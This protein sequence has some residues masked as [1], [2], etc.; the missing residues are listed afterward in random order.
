MLQNKARAAVNEKV[1]SD[2]YNDE[3]NVNKS[4]SDE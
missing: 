3:G 1:R 4:F 2:L